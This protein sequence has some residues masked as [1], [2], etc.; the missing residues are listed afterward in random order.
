MDRMLTDVPC[1]CGDDPSIGSLKSGSLHMQGRKRRQECRRFHDQFFLKSI[2]SLK[3]QKKNSIFARPITEPNRANG[4]ARNPHRHRNLIKD[5]YG[6][7]SHSIM[8]WQERYYYGKYKIC[9]LP[10]QALAWRFFR[11]LCWRPTIFPYGDM[12]PLV[13]RVWE[14]PHLAYWDWHSLV[15][16]LRDISPLSLIS[17][18][19]RTDTIKDLFGIFS[20][21]P[22]PTAD[23]TQ[24]CRPP[25]QACDVIFMPDF[26]I[27]QTDNR[28][29]H[30]TIDEVHNECV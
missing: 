4:P 21:L 24:S 29:L 7:T 10:W 1:T 3:D 23:S 17:H 15:P 19:Y 16:A 27:R 8:E 5:Y 9:R 28:T 14:S 6:S 18:R 12:V 20:K 25:W 30:L 11:R 2:G 26:L 22:A 13:S